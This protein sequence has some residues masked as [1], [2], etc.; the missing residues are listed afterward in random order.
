MVDLDEKT[1]L[2]T[3]DEF[4]IFSETDSNQSLDYQDK[5]KMLI[6]HVSL[7]FERFCNRKLK[8]RDFSY[9]M[10]SEDFDPKY[11]I[12]DGPMGFNFYFPTY[13]INSISEF[14]VGDKTVLP[15]QTFRDSN[16]Y[17]LYES[18]GLLV[19][20]R[21]FDYGYPKNVKALWNGGYKEDSI[22]MQSLKFM[23]F[24]MIKTILNSP[25]RTN[26]Q[27]EKIGNYSYTN[28]SLQ[29]IK[30]LHG[31]CPAILS[32]LSAYRREVI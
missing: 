31:L 13:P 3:L 32:S 10:E 15:A 6:N 17:Q 4:F 26:F 25:E 11:S 20:H 30:E 24:E 2:I 9:D 5:I 16:G 27:S 7:L 18:K 14:I 23:C 8:A 19:Y 22:E 21:G 12:F 29:N 1:A 28:F